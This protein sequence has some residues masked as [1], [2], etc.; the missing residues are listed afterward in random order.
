MGC[1][2]PAESSHAFP[3]VGEDDASGYVI[4]MAHGNMQWRRQRKGRC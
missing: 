3:L 2:G 4:G 1:I